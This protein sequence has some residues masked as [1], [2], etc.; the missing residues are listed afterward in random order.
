MKKLNKKELAELE[1]LKNIKD[2]EI[3]YSDIPEVNNHNAFKR[4]SNKQFNEFINSN[5]PL[6]TFIELIES[7]EPEMVSVNIIINASTSI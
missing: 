3:G 4:V 5:L 1:A 2:E 7:N 6:N